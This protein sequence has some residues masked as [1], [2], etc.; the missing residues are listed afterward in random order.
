[1]NPAAVLLA[2]L[3]PTWGV[4]TESPR[5]GPLMVSPDGRFLQY[6]D[7]APFFW[8][9]DTAW[10][11]LQRLDR[12][13]TERYLRDR[14]S[15]GF[16]VVQ[17]MVL[18]T[19]RDANVYG[20]PALV[21]G[22]PARPNLTPGNDPARPGE[23][24]YWDH[25]DWVLE[26]AATHGIYLGLVAAWGSMVNGGHLHAGNV[27]AYARFLARRYR[28]RP[29]VIWINGGDTRG[30]RHTEVW[31]ALGRTLKREDPGHLITF[32]PF[33]RTQSSTWFH[34]EPW[35]DLNMFQSGHRRYDQDDSPGAKGEDNWRYVR[36]DYAR[37][38]PKPTL[39]G[40]PSYEDIPQGLHDPSQPYWTAD[41]CRRYAYWSVLAGA[42]GH[43][44][45]HNAVMQMHKPG[46]GKGSY[47]VR[48]YWHEALND[49]GASQM[50]HL[51]RLVLSRPYY[52]RV[53]DEEAV[54]DNGQ[55]YEYVIVARGK[56][57]LFAYTYTGRSFR[58]R[59]GRIS[60][61]RVKAWWYD[62][63]TGAATPAGVFPNRGERLF[64]PPGDPRPGN[65]W[66]LVL[67][68]AAADFPPPGQERLN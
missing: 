22:D 62:P 46:V 20:V 50:Q 55:R 33:G 28:D 43:T 58:L 53:F 66:V 16:N 25:L 49:P 30:D 4:G 14:A 3:V 57:Y 11:L 54:V 67:D 1:M 63:R 31:Q 34:N 59:M 15:K 6:R 18:R 48:K 37:Q 2:V 45:G 68:D 21:D 40:E 32:H 7:G 23:Y 44:Y 51:K 47:G 27:E 8:L 36:E 12:E 64:D 17:V 5:V 42:C 52:E 24:D 19:P 56:R 38:P 35:L 13:E 29:N 60:G 10:L 9:G 41:D 61:D 65:D 39:D 26:R